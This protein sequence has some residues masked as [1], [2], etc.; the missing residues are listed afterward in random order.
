DKLA[1]HHSVIFRW[2]VG[3]QHPSRELPEHRSDLA[4]E[5]AYTRFSRIKLRDSADTVFGEVDL[6]NLEAVR[7]ELFEQQMPL[8]YLEF[9]PLGVTRQPDYLQPVL[10]R[11]WDRVQNIS[12][13]YKH[14]IGQIVFDVEIVVVERKVLFRIEN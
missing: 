14:H 11:R 12:R 8:G 1:F 3:R 7:L 13:S 5:A 10:K 6:L 2:V 4:L 9:L